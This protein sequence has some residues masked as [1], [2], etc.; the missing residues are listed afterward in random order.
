M[1]VSIG[2]E[3]LEDAAGAEDGAGAEGGSPV[4]DA[5]G[6]APGAGADDAG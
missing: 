6:E 1:L 5:A 2:C 4:G 3:F